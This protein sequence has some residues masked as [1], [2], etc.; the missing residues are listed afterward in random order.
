MFIRFDRIHE[1]NRQ[2]DRHRMMARPRMYS[3]AWQNVSL[4]TF[5]TCY[6]F[7]RLY[8]YLADVFKVIT[9]PAMYR[10]IKQ[11]AK[12]NNLLIETDICVL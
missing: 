8:R 1:R 7:R 3:S 11:H 6:N 10:R 12:S 9:Y 4:F 5:P 2:T